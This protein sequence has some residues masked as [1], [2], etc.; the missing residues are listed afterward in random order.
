LTRSQYLLVFAVP[1]IA[2]VVLVIGVVVQGRAEAQRDQNRAD[3]V[4]EQLRAETLAQF[5]SG[6]LANDTAAAWMCEAASDR[7]AGQRVTVQPFA[8]ASREVVDRF[9]RQLC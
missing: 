9:V 8:D 5:G 7:A 2:V 4:V 3:E 1:V 6:S